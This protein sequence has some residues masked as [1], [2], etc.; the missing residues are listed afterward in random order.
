[1]SEQ[2]IWS[3]AWLEWVGLPEHLN[4]RVRQGAWPVFK[5][6]VE[7]DCETNFRPAPFEITVTELARRTGTKADA[8][9]KVLEALR[10]KRF[11]SCFLPE[12]PDEEMLCQVTTPLPLPGA[13]D[14]VLARLP[15]SMQRDELRYLD[16]VEIGDQS[17]E[18]LRE[19]VDSYM[20]NVSHKMNAFILDEIKML[21]VRF[22][23]DQIRRIFARA[24][25]LGIDSLG[26]VT[27]E[28]VREDT[29]G[30]KSKRA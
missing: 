26:W 17:R 11:I 1:M 25:T 4:T 7:L 30:Q 13:R 24:R 16:E 3:P 20:N 2:R 19:L 8:L 5:K 14:A 9:V 28:L 22:R 21:A 23:T 6:L 10:K 29:G 15:R 27:R 18:Q 12:H